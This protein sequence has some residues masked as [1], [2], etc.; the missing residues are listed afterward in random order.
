MA[1][2]LRWQPGEVRGYL[3]PPRGSIPFVGFELL[4]RTRVKLF[5][6]ILDSAWLSTDTL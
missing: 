3:E 4:F 1:V 6:G 2:T 5:L